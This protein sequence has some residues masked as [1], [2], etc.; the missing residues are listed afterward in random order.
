MALAVWHS[1]ESNPFFYAMSRVIDQYFDSPPLAP[2]APDP[3]RFA[4]RGKLLEVVREAGAA[5][6]TERLVQCKIEAAM[7]VEDFW[8]LRIEMSEKLREK[9]G[10]LSV[11]RLAEVRRHAIESL[12]EYSTDGG[13]SFPAE[14][15][16]VSGSKVAVR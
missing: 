13:M 5:V 2:D 12:R 11:D 3:F 4:S 8:T 15:L 1:V 10:T 6:P 14:V 9:I 16:V 7:A